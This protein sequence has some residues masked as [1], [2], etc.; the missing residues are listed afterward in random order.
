MLLPNIDPIKAP[1]ITPPVM[2]N[3]EDEPRK[4]PSVN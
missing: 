1:I 4:P 3:N 2:P